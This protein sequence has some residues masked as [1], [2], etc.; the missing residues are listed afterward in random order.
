MDQ[1]PFYFFFAGTKNVSTLRDGIWNW[2]TA[3]P[4]E[5]DLLRSVYASDDSE[6][7]VHSEHPCF[8]DGADRNLWVR[9]RKIREEAGPDR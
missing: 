1:F 9:S 8:R 2:R 3:L 5:F 7:V 4:E 6:P